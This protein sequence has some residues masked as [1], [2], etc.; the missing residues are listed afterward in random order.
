MKV[1]YNAV[2]SSQLL[3][4]S[5]SLASQLTPHP[6][7]DPLACGFSAIRKLE[8][9]SSVAKSNFAPLSKPID[10]ASMKTFEGVSVG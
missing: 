9:I 7:P 1:V 4:I 5:Y 8:P 10:I 3:D 2:I 6:Q